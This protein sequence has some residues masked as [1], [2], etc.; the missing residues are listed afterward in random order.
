[1]NIDLLQPFGKN[2]Q[3]RVFHRAQSPKTN[4]IFNI[5]NNEYNSK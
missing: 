3:K 5:E 2:N 1:M 4:I